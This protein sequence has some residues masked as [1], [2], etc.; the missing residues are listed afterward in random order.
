[1]N[2]SKV[3]LTLL[4]TCA[5]LATTTA[6]VFADDSSGVSVRN[7]CRILPPS[8][9]KPEVEKCNE[10]TFDA[11]SSYDP[12]NKKITVSW[13]F[14]DGAT[15]D[16][17][18]VKHTYEKAGIYTVTLKVTNNTGVACDTAVTTQTVKVN[19]PPHAVFT[20][21]DMVC[22][23]QP[24]A[25]DASATTA[26]APDKTTYMWDFGDGTTDKGMKVSKVYKKAGEYQ[27]WLLVNDNEN[28]TCSQ[29]STYKNIKIGAAPIANAGAD[30][31]TSY[32]T[33]EPLKA[34][35]DAS[36]STSPSGDPLT[37]TWDFGD[38]TTGTGKTV[39]HVYEKPGNYVAKVTVS[40]GSSC[41]SDVASVKVNLRVVSVVVAHAGDDVSACLSDTITFDGSTSTSSSG[42]QLTYRWDLGDGSSAEGAQVT[43]VYQKSGTYRV[44][45][46]V[47]DGSEG[48]NSTN[49]DVKNVTVGAPPVALLKRVGKVCIGDAVSF[50]ASGSKVADGKSLKYMWDFG[51]GTTQN[52][53]S[54]VAHVYHK[55]GHYTASVEVKKAAGSRCKPVSTICN[56]SMA[57]T[58]VFVNTPPVAIAGSNLISCVGSEIVFDGSQSSD[59]DGDAL[60]YQWNFGDGT[61]AEGAKG[62]HGFAKQ[63]TYKVT[64]TV[65]DGSGTDCSKSQ[66]S[67]TVLVYGK[68]VSV[69]KVK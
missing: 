51:D 56:S 55:A 38:G 68:P 58:D 6:I 25:F 5:V 12:N 18:V 34:T 3:L 21:P 36:D 42:K 45:L 14:G 61:T 46:T 33:G 39:D 64:L 27:V 23:G 17:P 35:F 1:M 67:F 50:D 60:T 62:T 63:G 26:S 7:R 9:A 20:G 44:T 32:L 43:H 37:Y 11:T 4:V 2:R 28:T 8:A 53:N 48:K 52:G 29:D 22:L 13:D 66:E 59:A 31:D 30:I 47:S 69:I 41:G 24:A 16:Q 49:M 19:M 54:K 65:D 10:F 15:S 40:D 57:S